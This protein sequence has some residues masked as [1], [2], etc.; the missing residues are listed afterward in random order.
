MLQQFFKQKNEAE[1]VMETATDPEFII[2]KN[3]GYTPKQRI[4][5]SLV[6]LFTVFLVIGLTYWSILE[7]KQY[8]TREFRR[9][10]PILGDKGIKGINCQA[11]TISK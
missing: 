5:Q 3:I 8:R 10:M 7:F 1:T 4:F 2:W 6:S 11:I 9:I